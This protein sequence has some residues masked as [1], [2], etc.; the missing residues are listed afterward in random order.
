V[1]RAT[2]PGKERQPAGCHFL[3]EPIGDDVGANTQDDVVVIHHDS[4][5]ADFNSEDHDQ[6]PKPFHRPCLSMR[7][8]PEG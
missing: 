5:G 3:I 4:V 1:T 6:L 8:V 2:T 7:E